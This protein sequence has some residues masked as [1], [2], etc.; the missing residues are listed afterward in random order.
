MNQLGLLLATP[1][2]TKYT[3]GTCAAALGLPN[4]SY[5]QGLNKLMLSFRAVSIAISL[6]ETHVISK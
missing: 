4:L 5:D 6:P 2:H 3:A 1:N